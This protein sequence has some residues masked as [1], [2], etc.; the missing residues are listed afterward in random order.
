M[1]VLGPNALGY[2]NTAAKVALKPFQPG[3][4]LLPG[5]IAVVSQSGNVTVQ[6]MNMARSF[7]VGLSFAVSTGNEMDVSVG[8]VVDFLAEDEATDAIAV[9]AESFKDPQAFLEASRRARANGK[10]VV[11]LKVGRSEAAARAALAH[12]G[13]LVGNDEVI[14]AFLRSAGVVRVSSLEDLLTVAD[15]YAH[16]GPI[17]RGAALLTISGGTCDI[18]ADR[19]EDVGLAMPEFASETVT[20]LKEILP[21]FASVHNPLDITGAAVTDAT[22]FARALETVVEDAGIG[23]V[24]AAQ[25]IDHQAENLEWG[26][27]CVASMSAVAQ[28]SE[29]PVVLANTSVRH[30]T[31]RVREIRREVG[32]PAL[33]GGVDRI[34]PAIRQIQEWSV[35]RHDD[36]PRE[37]G[38]VELPSVARTGSWTERICRP[39]LESAGIPVAPGQVVT[40]ADE[41]AAVAAD[42]DDPVVIKV[43]SDDILHKTEV[44]GVALGVAPCDVGEQAQA[45]LDRVSAA[46]PG[47]TIEGLLVGPQRPDGIDLLVGV[48]REPGWGNVLAIGLGGVW[49]EVLQDVQR[50]ALPAD[51]GEVE[52]AL[53]SLRAWPLLDGARGAAPVDVEGLVTAIVRIADLSLVLGDGLAAFEVNPLRVTE[54]GVEALDAAVVWSASS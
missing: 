20:A 42:W 4:D 10:L 35:H 40:S 47:A 25:E 49:T 44:G 31:P 45:M 5:R 13:S 53:R 18:V 48:V 43:L 3:E 28:R 8:D 7:D 1:V 24:V 52:R 38:A 36:A 34:L 37:A 6:I 21:S 15:T 22:L 23:V 39:L 32:A 16:T 33:F 50:V 14:D 54:G 17:D 27:E 11:C 12:T 19:A 30:L 29:V 26:L 46:A 41:A 9:F 2:V 51:E